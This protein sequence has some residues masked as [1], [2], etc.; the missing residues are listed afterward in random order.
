MRKCPKLAS[1]SFPG[2]LPVRPHALCAQV[3]CR[4]ARRASSRTWLLP[5]NWAMNQRC[6]NRTFLF[7]SLFNTARGQKSNTVCSP[8]QGS[9]AGAH[10]LNPCVSSDMYQ[11]CRILRSQARAPLTNVTQAMHG[12]S[13]GT[14]SRGRI[15]ESPAP[16]SPNVSPDGEASIDT[17]QGV[18]V[19]NG[20]RGRRSRRA[21]RLSVGAKG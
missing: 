10:A 3:V 4:V 18:V 14:N 6:T 2:V 5:W 8:D 12:S 9:P 15:G 17:A 11:L 19:E 7:F 13:N 21:S 16:P 20:T 1:W